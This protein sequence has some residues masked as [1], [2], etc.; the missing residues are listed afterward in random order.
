METFIQHVLVVDYLTNIMPG[1]W[2]PTVRKPEKQA[3]EKL[4]NFFA[5]Y[6]FYPKCKKESCDFF[7]WKIYTPIQNLK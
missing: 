1:T 2:A 6:C 4:C 7:R 5:K 3:E